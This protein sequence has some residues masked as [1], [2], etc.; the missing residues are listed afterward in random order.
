MK[1]KSLFGKLGMA[2]V[3]MTCAMGFQSCLDD[4]DNNYYY[5]T[6]PNALVTV[7]LQLTIR[8]SCSWMTV[9]HCCR[10]T[11]RRRPLAKNR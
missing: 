4:D 6:Y 11:L 3:A 7:K 1:L 8:S 10:L 9:L 5:L 2:L